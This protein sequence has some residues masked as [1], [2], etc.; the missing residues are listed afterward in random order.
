MLRASLLVTCWFGTVYAAD[1]N[2]FRGPTGTGT[3]PQADPP[4]TWNPQS[5]TWHTPLPGS[6]WS[7]PV[8]VGATLFVTAAVGDQLGQP[9]DMQAGVQAPQSMPLFGNFTK[10][11]DITI[12]W[13]LFALDAGTGAI[14]WTRTVTTGKPKYPIHPSNSYATETV[15]V[16][17][18]RV[19]AYFGATGTL[20]AFDFA[21]QEQWKVELGA[22]LHA[23]GFGS[24]SS[25]VCHGDTVF[26]AN[27]NEK[28]AFVA[29]FAVATGKEVW[30]QTRTK[31]GSAWASPF[32]WQNTQRTEL[33]ACGDKLVT[34]HDPATGAELWRIGK[35]D[36]AFA[37]SPT[38]LGDVLL[39][40]A[41]SPFSASPLYA[42]KPGATG[43]ISLKKGETGNDYIAW[44]R[45]K[46][47]VGMSSPVAVEGRLYF[48]GE[49][50]LTCYDTQTGQ[51]VYKERL[52]KSRMTT[53]SLVVAG[54]QILAVDETGRAT[55]IKAG[56]TFTIVGTGDLQDTFWASPAVVD[57]SVYLRGLKGIYCVRK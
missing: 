26:V 17:A 18:N 8:I 3:A 49:G 7:Q 44:F 47:K 5:V 51:E 35:I 50:L 57:R 11:P 55:W 25:P 19:M 41:S 30:R 39:F 15:C 54:N 42:V 22:Y 24:G 6:G 40:G 9:K 32:I 4:L 34:S 29:A 2:Q 33:I 23:S 1:F 31:P 12:D 27:F 43:D 14:R 48:A 46:A 10:A 28:N 36:T 20:A 56:P 16:T 37:P 21:G 53:A 38:A 13:K 52:P 45:T